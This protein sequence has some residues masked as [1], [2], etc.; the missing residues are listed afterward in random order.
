MKPLKITGFYAAAAPNVSRMA[1]I[2]VGVTTVKILDIDLVFIA[3]P[4]E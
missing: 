1:T 3:A 4:Q 2:I